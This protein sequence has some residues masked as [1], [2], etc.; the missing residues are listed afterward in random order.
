[1][2]QPPSEELTVIP[3]ETPISESTPLIPSDSD[4]AE[5]ADKNQRNGGLMP[6]SN[7]AVARNGLPAP[8]FDFENELERPWPATFER[9]ISLLAGP[10]LDTDFIE[11]ITKSPKITPNLS[12]RRVCFQIPTDGICMI[13]LFLITTV[14]LVKLLI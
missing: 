14:F 1:M 11:Q 7:N 9:S 10:T 8:V 12:L 6:P 5:V 4:V 2:D 13:I 3:D